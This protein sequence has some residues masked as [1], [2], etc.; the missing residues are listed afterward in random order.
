MTVQKC[1][2]M[3]SSELLES[4]EEGPFVKLKHAIMATRE[5][6]VKYADQITGLSSNAKVILCVATTLARILGSKKGKIDLTEVTLGLLREYCMDAFGDAYGDL[7][8]EDFKSLLF[9]LVD[10]GLLNLTYVRRLP[11]ERLNNLAMIPIR[12]LLPLQEVETALED[13]LYK[14]DHYSNIRGRVE[15]QHRH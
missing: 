10:A 11:K 12:L 14:Q 13:G 8:I 6:V 2:E 1:R 15:I 4:N 3:C 9:M 7:G 5:T